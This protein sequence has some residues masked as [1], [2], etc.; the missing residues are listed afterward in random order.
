MKIA[1]VSRTVHSGVPERMAM[2]VN[3][4]T[5]HE[6]VA[7]VPGA[8]IDGR[9][10][11]E[12]GEGSANSTIRNVNDEQQRGHVLESADVIHC[13]YNTSLHDLGRPD[14]ARKKLCVWHLATKWND[15][16]LRLFPEGTDGVLPIMSAEGWDRYGTG[17]WP[18]MPQMP[19][20]FLLDHSAMQPLPFSR[21]TR[22]ASMSPRVMLDTTDDGQPIAAPR[23]SKK[24]AAALR[25]LKFRRLHG[26]DWQACMRRKAQAWV[27]IDDVVNPLVHQSGFEYL[28]LGVPCIN[29]S[30]KHLQ[31][32]IQNA[33]G[34]WC[35]FVMSDMEDV[36]LAVSDAMDV[37]VGTWEHF[38]TKARAWMERNAHPRET[39]ARYIDLYEGAR[40]P[41]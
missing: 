39:I 1:Y 5:E 32:T 26:L 22:H 38:S 34:G 36:R 30:D 3:Q 41:S 27:G 35:P 10:T 2:A 29:A 23:S 7:L 24:V 4:Y 33:Y 21:R 15:G 20:V 9:R 40:V 19:V 14:L 13:L 11:F 12:K 6:A 16:F 25:G 18:S 31:E 8:W 37:P 17:P 28:A